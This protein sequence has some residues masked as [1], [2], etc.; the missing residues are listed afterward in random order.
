MRALYFYLYL[1]CISCI[2]SF[3]RKSMGISTIF[4]L[5]SNIRRFVLSSVYLLRISGANSH[6]YTQLFVVFACPH[7]FHDTSQLVCF[8]LCKLFLFRLLSSA[9]FVL[10]L[11]MCRVFVEFFFAVQSTRLRL[12]N[13]RT[14]RIFRFDFKSPTEGS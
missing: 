8:C 2:F 11:V 14:A 13:A 7:L 4:Q 10:M 1:I 12:V 6:K 5:S 3:K 9:Y